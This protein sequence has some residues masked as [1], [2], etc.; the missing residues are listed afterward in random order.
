MINGRLHDAATL[1]E[2]GNHP[3]TRPAFPWQRKSPG[4]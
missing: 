1:N 3:K 2:I 4:R